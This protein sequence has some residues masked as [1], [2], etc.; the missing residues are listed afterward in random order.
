MPMRSMTRHVRALAL[1]MTLH[2]CNKDKSEST[3]R[4]QGA[5]DQALITPEAKAAAEQIF[6]TRCAACHGPQ[7]KGDGAASAGL[8]PKPRDFTDP[9]WQEGVT[10]EHLEKIVTYG[11][12]AVG[13]SPAM[14]PNPDL[15][16]KPAVVAGLRA[17]IRALKG[18]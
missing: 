2:A 15:Q 1:V 9:S 16:A 11:G 17:H 5:Q 10:D 6:S 18:K 7:G 13:K 12:A 14:P 3:E 4:A 8:D